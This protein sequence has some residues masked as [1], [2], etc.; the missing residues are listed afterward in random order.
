MN[1]IKRIFWVLGCQSFVLFSLFSCIENDSTNYIDLTGEWKFEADPMDKGI[2]EKWFSEELKD[3]INLPGSMAENNR[4]NNPSVDQEWTGTFWN[5]EWFTNEKYAQYREPDNLKLSFWLTPDKVY[6]GPAWYQ[7][8][9]VIPDSWK[10]SHIRLFL[11]RP[12]WETTVWIDD[13]IIGMK[14]TLG[15]P[16]NYELN[17][18]NLNPG[19]HTITIRVD[20]RVKEVNVGLNAHSISDNTQTNWN[21]IVGDIRLVATPRI[22]MEELKIIP[23]ISRKSVSVKL[24]IKNNSGNSQK[25]KLTLTAEKLNG[26]FPN[27]KTINQEVDLDIGINN[28]DLSYQ[29]GDNPALWDEFNPNTYQMVLALKSDSGTD[30]KHV[31]FGMREFKVDG[32]HFSINNNPVFLRGTLECAIF[33]LTGYPPTKT[34][35]WER[36]FRIIK[37]HGLN[38]MRFHS[39]CPPKAA[40]QAADKMGIYLQVEASAWASI[41]DG[42]PID[43]WLYEEAESILNE[44]GNHPSFVMM[45]HGNEPAGKNHKEYLIEFVDYFKNYDDTKIYTSGAGWPYIDNADYFNSPAPRI[46]HWNQNLNSII[47]KSEPQTVFDYQ[48]LTDKTPMPVVSHEMGQW[49]VFPNFN[50]M[51]KYTGVLK[52]KNFEIFKATLENSNLDHLADSLMLASGKLQT[53]C[54][55]ADIEAALRTKHFGGFQLLDLHDFPGQGTA[56]VGVLDAFWDEKGYVTPDEF[57]AFSG[58]TVPLARLEK[59]VFLNSDTLKA[60][61]EIAHFGENPILGVEPKWELIDNNKIVFAKGSLKASDI[62]IGNGIPLGKVTIPLIAIESPKKLTLSVSVGKNTNSWDVWVYPSENKS[63]NNEEIRLV[64]NLDNETISF[65][66]AGG[67]VLLSTVKGSVKGEFGGDIGIGFSSIFWNTSWTNGQKPHT[68]G[69][70]CDPIHPAFVQFPTEFHSNWQ[71]WDSMSYSNAIIIDQFKGLN[72]IVRVIDDWFNN[73]NLALIFEVKVGKGKLIVSGIDFHTGIERRIEAQQLLFSLENY[74][75]S[76]KFSPSY[77]IEIE[78]LQKFYNN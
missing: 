19:K 3:S 29:M 71:W 63:R 7:K 49:C 47:N 15:T 66:E 8:E 53:L 59:R 39:W 78:A 17:I 77:P 54:Y 27:E 69:I 21:G 50:E 34:E 74:M 6:Y 60:S 4:G 32:K 70:L 56:L 9:V 37:D 61:I 40:F 14:N 26:D 30:L 38:H 31:D 75:A 45:A 76:V 36:I 64:K 62:E 16:H 68:L 1:N 12:H 2:T 55:K 43:Q 20:N 28:I 52:P 72:P 65:L 57:R 22:Y 10:E 48:E 33:P 51:P 35:D 41:G 24:K 18:E 11:E 58:Q 67:K 5:K 42:E 13:Q 73:R 46:Q 25:A 44:Y 23:D